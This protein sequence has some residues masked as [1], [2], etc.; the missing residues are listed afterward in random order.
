LKNQQQDDDMKLSLKI[1]ERCECFGVG[2]FG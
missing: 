2:G 1:T